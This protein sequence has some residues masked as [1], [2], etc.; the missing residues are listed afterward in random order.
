MELL[1][2]LYVERYRALL[3]ARVPVDGRGARSGR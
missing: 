1:C 3:E 2:D